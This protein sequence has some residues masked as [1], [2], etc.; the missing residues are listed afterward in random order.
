MSTIPDE[1]RLRAAALNNRG[2]TGDKAELCDAE[3]AAIMLDFANLIE[4][5]EGL[6]EMLHAAGKLADAARRVVGGRDLNGFDIAPATINTL[7]ASAD[8]LRLAVDAYDAEIIALA[9]ERET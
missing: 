4:K 2:Y 6:A 1:L 8:M 3:N 9:R 5:H 7:T